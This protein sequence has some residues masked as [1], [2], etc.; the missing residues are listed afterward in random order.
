VS[1]ITD[2][3]QAIPVQIARNGLRAIVFGLGYDGALELRFMPL[4]ADIQHGDLLVTSGID[5]TYPPGLPVATVASV[6]HNAAY[7]FARITCF[8]ASGVG[9]HRQALILS[10]GEPLPE[11]PPSDATKSRKARPGRGR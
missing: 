9:S 7:P 4:N 5:G 1:L 2:R 10:R 3:D 6:E 8:P 11:R